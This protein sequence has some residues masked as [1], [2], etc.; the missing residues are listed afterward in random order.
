MSSARHHW[1]KLR[2]H[3]YICRQCGAGKVN[4][5]DAA[6]AWFTTFH[7]PDGRSIVAR[8]VPPCEAGPL[9]TKYLAKYAADLAVPF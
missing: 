1:V 8:R 5:R 6:G 3:V 9:T 4:G 2:L 7:P